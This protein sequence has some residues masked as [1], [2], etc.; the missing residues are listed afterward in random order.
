MSLSSVVAPRAVLLGRAILGSALALWLA[1]GAIQ[2]QP[3][4]QASGPTASEALAIGKALAAEG[5]YREAIA[6]LRLA[7]EREPADAYLRLELA[8]LA[9][10]LGRADEAVEQAR[11]ARRLSPDDPDVLAGVADVLL[12]LAGEREELLVEAQQALE[13]RLELVPDEP[14]TLHSLGRLHHS[15]GDF[16]RAEEMYRRLLA[17]VPESRAAG[18]QLLNLLLQRGKKDE[19]AALLR[20]QVAETPDALDVRLSLA[21]LLSELEEHA[22]AVTLLRDAPA[23]QAKHPEV[24][25]RLAFELYRTGD[26]AGAAGLIDELLAQADRDAASSA[27]ASSAGASSAGA[28]AEPSRLVLQLRLF[29]ALLLEEQGR[30]AEAVAD[31]ERLHATMPGDPEVGLSLARLLAEGERSAEAERLLRD[32]LARLERAGDG[33][34]PTAGRVRLELAQILSQERDWQAVLALADVVKP[35][36]GEPG[37]GTAAMLLR[38]DALV[39]LGRAEE[40]LAG[41]QP[42]SGVATEAVHAKRAEVL[43]ELGRDVEAGEELARLGEGSEAVRRA[44][45]VYQRAGRHERAV[46]LLERLLGAEP[47]S[48]D[49]RF[50]LAAAYERTGQHPRA[51]DAFQEL[52]RR[53]PDFHMALN[54]LGYMWAEKGENLAD[55]RRLVERALE[56][57]PGNPAY[58]DSL[59]WIYFRQGD[60]RLA[61]EQL[62]R[63]ARLLPRDGTVQEHLGDVL[64]ALGNAAEARTAYERALAAGD[65]NAEQVQRKLREV[66]RGL[67]R[68]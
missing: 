2:A 35:V 13:R 17:A 7:V 44:A 48:T 22:E 29:R 63:A 51:V 26:V 21:D 24:T 27:G 10:R 68:R 61:L 39:G 56:L 15:R 58:I 11:E 64:R 45:D 31:L 66:E 3:A 20:E 59:G 47:E 36:A 38:T 40:A 41:L 16:A 19:A 67:P 30:G 23:E 34:T 8:G 43:L 28:S 60:H 49:L 1:A 57:D 18:S 52:L 53:Q 25:R 5:E 46:P 62:Q 6:Q 54:Y 50:R 42:G 12:G 9:Y 37:L 14:Q 4:P 32:L 65:D 33:E 55:A